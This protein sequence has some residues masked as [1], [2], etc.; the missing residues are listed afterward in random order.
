MTVEVTGKI[1]LELQTHQPV[2]SMLE[3]ELEGTAVKKQP[4]VSEILSAGAVV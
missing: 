1:F 4:T 3:K 2:H